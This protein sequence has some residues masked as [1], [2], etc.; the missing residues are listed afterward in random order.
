[1]ADKQQLAPGSAEFGRLEYFL[2]LSL[3][4][5]TARILGAWGLYN[6]HLTSAF[7]RKARV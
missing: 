1:M 4:A 5:S 7:E 2:Q 3:K 6:P